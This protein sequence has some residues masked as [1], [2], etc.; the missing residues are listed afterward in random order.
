MIGVINLGNS[1]LMSL[2]NSLDYLN[3]SYNIVK[4]KAQLVNVD[5]IILPGVGTFGNGVEQLQKLGLFESIVDEVKKNNK[6]ILGIC[7]GMQLLFNKSQ[8]SPGYKGLSLLNGD[9]I[10]LPALETYSIPRIGWAESKINFDFLGM[11]K[12]DLIDFYYIH[13]FYVKPTDENIVSIITEGM[14]TASVQNKHIYGCQFHPEKSHR[15]G[16]EIL[17]K[18]SEI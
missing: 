6:P 2:S 5:K 8:E 18:F 17:K 1:N 3:I 7:L 9:V 12:D 15:S 14:I 10:D 11:K 16:L 13:S 4:E